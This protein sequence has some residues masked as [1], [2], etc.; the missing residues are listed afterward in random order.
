MNDDFNSPVLLAHLFDGVKT[1]NSI[2]DGKETISKD[3]L[4]LLKKTFHDFIF[5]VLGLKEEKA[6]SN[7]DELGNNLMQL[8]IKIREEAKAK[9]D[10]ATSDEIRNGLAKTKITIKDT[11]NGVVWEKEK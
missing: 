7:N 5:D 4:A 11:K 8:V 1:I 10:F 2:N 9:K 6:A 3:D